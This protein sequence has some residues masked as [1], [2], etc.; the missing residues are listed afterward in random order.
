MVAL[1]WVL[2]VSP[3]HVGSC[4][5][6]IIRDEKKEIGTL[7][8]I[9][10]TGR[11]LLKMRDYRV[12]F[13]GVT[14]QPN[15]ESM[16]DL[17]GD[18]APEVIFEAWSGGAH[19][20]QR[21]E[22]WSVGRKPRRML[23]YDKG[24]IFGDERDLSFRDLDGDG[25]PEILSWYDG[26]AYTYAGPYSAPVP[27]VLK[28]ERGQYQEA[29]GRYPAVLRQEITHAWK[30]LRETMA[31]RQPISSWSSHGSSVVYLLALADLMKSRPQMLRDLQKM[32]SAS[33]FAWAK[34]QLPFITDCLAKR[35]ERFRPYSL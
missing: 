7:A 35:R 20:S 5:V 32:L 26:F 18:G 19:G 1:L 21:Y 27:L 23:S 11:F 31:E 29:T 4:D 16:R 24:N 8:L 13:L 28:L 22:I 2:L 12:G 14:P 30:R 17:D 34:E 10:R 33:D 3:I 6:K 25:T 15:H 9:D